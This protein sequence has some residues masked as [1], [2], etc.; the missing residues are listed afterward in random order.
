[1][2]HNFTRKFCYYKVMVNHPKVYCVRPA[3]AVVGPNS[4]VVVPIQLEALSDFTQ[5]Q[6][7]K[8]KFQILYAEADNADVDPEEF[9][10]TLRKS[11]QKCFKIPAE[12]IPGTPRSPNSVL[13]VALAMEKA[14][15][16]VT[17]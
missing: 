7:Q 17:D 3:K 9:F 1:M 10:K 2:V 15:I 14:D 5:Q 13:A 11:A 12:F 6:K 8:H 16:E 4:N